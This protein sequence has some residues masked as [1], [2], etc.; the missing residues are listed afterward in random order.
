MKNGIDKEWTR[1]DLPHNRTEV[2]FDCIKVRFFTFLKMG[3][4]LLLFMLPSLFVCFLSDS[5]YSELY[6]A[7]N[8]GTIDESVYSA[9]YS[10]Y[11][12]A[13][14]VAYVPCFIIAAIGLSGI[15]KVIRRLVFGEAVFFRQDFF[16]GMR[17]SAVQYAVIGLIAALLPVLFN[18]AVPTDKTQ[19]TILFVLKCLSVT[20]VSPVLA[21]SLCGSTVY[22]M[23]L[24]TLIKNSV[25]LYFANLPKTLIFIAVFALSFLITLIG[26]LMI[27]YLALALFFV[28]VCPL[29]LTAWFLFCCY[30]FDKHMN[31]D[32][33]PDLY[34]KGVFRKESE[35]K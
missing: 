32:N 34:D 10:S 18:G 9:R 24:F 28:A 8:S 20:L 6:L 12:F 35:N 30:V 1:D 26:D 11:A 15:M 22:K 25:I 33:F 13:F 14:S 31:K 2:F 19:S 16:D 5:A 4:V 23:R 21:F 3:V 29:I 17:Q 27:K 7:L